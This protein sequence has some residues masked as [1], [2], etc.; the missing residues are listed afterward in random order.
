M[1]KGDA[2]LPPGQA[3]AEISN[4]SH[5]FPCFQSQ[6]ESLCV[7]NKPMNFIHVINVAVVSKAVV[8]LGAVAFLTD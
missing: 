8:G 7:N 6:V 3:F 1:E 4:I 5:F 2:S